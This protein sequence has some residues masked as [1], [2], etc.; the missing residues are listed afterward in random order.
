MGEKINK[1]EKTVIAI[2]SVLLVV[3]A[4]AAGCGV[5]YSYATSYVGT[6]AGE[7]SPLGV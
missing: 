2:I 1:K 5:W 3:V 6:V 4:L 7:K